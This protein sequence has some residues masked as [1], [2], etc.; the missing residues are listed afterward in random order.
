VAGQYQKVF[1]GIRVQGERILVD[2]SGEGELEE[3]EKIA[4]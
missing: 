1:P 2:S 3:I 4:D